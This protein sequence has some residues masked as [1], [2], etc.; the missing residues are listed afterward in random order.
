MRLRVG[1]AVFKQCDESRPV[2]FAGNDETW[3]PAVNPPRCHFKSPRSQAGVGLGLLVTHLNRQQGAPL[4][5][6]IWGWWGRTVEARGGWSL[7]LLSPLHLLAH[8]V[9]ET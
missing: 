6:G 4:V 3:K 8:D 9:L 7:F 5:V 1:S 2:H